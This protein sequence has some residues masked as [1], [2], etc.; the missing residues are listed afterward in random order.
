MTLVGGTRKENVVL[1]RLSTA[2]WT[3]RRSNESILKEMNPGCSLQGLMR[4]LS[5][6]PVATR[7]EDP[8][9]WKGPWCQERLMAK[10][11]KQSS[12]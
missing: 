3:A 11:E 8:T 5:S 4:N 1:E 10:G 6:D 12:G 9:H 2:P 7:Y